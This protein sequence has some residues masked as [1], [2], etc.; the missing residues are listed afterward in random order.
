MVMKKFTSSKKK[1]K[2]NKLIFL[3]YL[4]INEMNTQ[5]TNDMII[6][7]KR[8]REVPRFSLFLNTVFFLKNSNEM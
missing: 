6:N 5:I 3:F 4:M 1:K 7:F 2:K 8:F